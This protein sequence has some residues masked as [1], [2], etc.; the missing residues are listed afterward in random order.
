M[1]MQDRQIQAVAQF[2]KI[3][4]DPTRLRILLELQEKEKNVSMLC[5]MLKM[6]QPTVSHHLGILRMGGVVAT[7]RAG[8]EIFYFIRD[9]DKPKQAKALRA[10][11]ENGASLQKA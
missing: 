3:L 1:A 11:L 7:K 10:I 8:K 2:F 6:A 9:L 4:G 5:K